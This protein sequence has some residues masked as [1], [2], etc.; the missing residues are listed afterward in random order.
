MAGIIAGDFSDTESG[1]VKVYYPHE[2]QGRLV[3]KTVLTMNID[4][5]VTLMGRCAKELQIPEN[6]LRPAVDGYTTGMSFAGEEDFKLHEKDVAMS[7]SS[8]LQKQ[9]QD[10]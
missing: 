3:G 6:V 8:K 4:D 5:A 1:E 9:P 10:N 7:L 2:R